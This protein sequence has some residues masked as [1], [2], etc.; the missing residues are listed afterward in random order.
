MKPEGSLPAP[1]LN[2]M[3]P[4]HAPFIPLLENPFSYYPHIYL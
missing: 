4:V 3:K 1:I 2:V